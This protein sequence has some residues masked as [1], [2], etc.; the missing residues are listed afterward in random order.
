MVPRFILDRNKY[1]GVGR[2][3]KSDYRIF[4]SNV[5]FVRNSFTTN[6]GVELGPRRYVRD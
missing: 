2:P 5:D 6:F 1:R 4:P 3:R